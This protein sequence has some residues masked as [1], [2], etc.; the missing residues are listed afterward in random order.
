MKTITLESYSHIPG[1]AWEVGTCRHAS[2]EEAAA[3]AAVD[4]LV[5]GANLPT[6]AY[7]C[8]LLSAAPEGVEVWAK[9]TVTTLIDALAESLSDQWRPEDE[10]GLEDD[11]AALAQDH[12]ELGLQKALRYY[13][14]RRLCAV[15][16][17]E[18][19]PQWWAPILAKVAAEE[20]AP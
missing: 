19:T 1:D 5:V 14:Q 15:A 20:V 18:L 2:L 17:V 13:A 11:A 9:E 8:R 3:E 6:E 10:D 7:L 12:F 4:H 16:R